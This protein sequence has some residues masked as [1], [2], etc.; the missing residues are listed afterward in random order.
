MT[1][2]RYYDR[3]GRPISLQ[4]WCDLSEDLEYK[5]VKQDK[6]LGK[7]VST[8]W[9]GLDHSFGG[10]PLIFETKVFATNQH[11]EV[12]NWSELAANRYSTEEQALKGHEEMCLSYI[13]PLDLMV[14]KLKEDDEAVVDSDQ[15]GAPEVAQDG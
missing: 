5:T 8:I 12:E 10:P 13:K 4:R 2:P 6:N 3:G 9:L 1:R 14:Q 7:M 15:G 11:G